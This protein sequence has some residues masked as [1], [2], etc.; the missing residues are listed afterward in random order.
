MII[1]MSDILC[2]TNRGLCKEDFFR[3]MEQIAG[4]HP[5]GIILREKDL[6]EKEYKSLAKQVLAI[7]EKYN[8]TCVLHS[9][10]GVARELDTTA[11]H[12]P[13]PILRT[14]KSDERA[15]FTILGSSCH[16]IEE[17]KEAERLGC[18]YIIAGHI[19]PTDCKKGVPG[20]GLDFL[21]EVRESVS[22]PVYAIGGID[23]QNITEVRKTGAAGVCIMSGIMT[24]EYPKE[25][26]LTLEKKQEE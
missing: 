10:I 4:E 15:E 14:L 6:S 22:I 25:Y 17:A 16:S 20:R 21:R 23:A 13:M 3:R 24:C 5:K 9:F 1:Y 18:T 7:C 8:T 12:V 26:L 11:V 2:I 19:F